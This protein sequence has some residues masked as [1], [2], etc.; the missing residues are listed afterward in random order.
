MLGVVLWESLDT[1][2]EYRLLDHQQIREPASGDFHVHGLTVLL[3]FPL[4]IE[5]FPN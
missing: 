4:L 2:L 5:A 3:H 1:S